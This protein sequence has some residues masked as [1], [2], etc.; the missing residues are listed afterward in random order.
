MPES[1]VFCIL[2]LHVCVKRVLFLHVTVFFD[3]HNVQKSVTH[4]KY[5][6]SL[7][8][9]LGVCIWALFGPALHWACRRQVCKGDDFYPGPLPSGLGGFI[10]ALFGPALHWACRRQVCKGDDFNKA[11]PAQLA[12]PQAPAASAP[13]PVILRQGRSPCSTLQLLSQAACS[14]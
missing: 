8:S 5:P 7:P 4:I 14:R 2:F 10:W 9:G 6:G 1:H 13:E 11:V 12:P 3:L